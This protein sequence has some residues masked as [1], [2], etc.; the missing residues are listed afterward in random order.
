MSTVLASPSQYV[1]QYLLPSFAVH[2]QLGWAHFSGFDSMAIAS[3]LMDRPRVH[4]V[5]SISSDVARPMA[6]HQKG[7]FLS[8]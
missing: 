5:T 6:Y 3:L 1:L 8:Q 2:A 7:F 4:C